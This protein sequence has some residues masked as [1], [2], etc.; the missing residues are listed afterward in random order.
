MDRQ[1]E[2]D[3]SYKGLIRVA[4]PIA[5]GTFVQFLMVFTDNFFLSKVT[6]NALNGAGISAMIYV[7]LSMFIIGLASGE[8]ILVARRNGE[9]RL[10]EAGEVFG[11]ALVVSLFLSVALFILMQ[12]LLHTFLSVFV[13][14]EH[15]LDHT[16]RFLDI[17]SIGIFFYGTSLIFIGFYIGIA[18]SKVLLYTTLITAGVNIFLD[19][20]LIFGNAGFPELGLEGAAWAT[21]TAEICSLVYLVGYAVWH[22]SS[23][24]YSLLQGLTH[25][26][27]GIVRSL[28][29]VSFPIMIQQVLALATWTAFFLIVEKLGEKELMASNIVRN[30]YL[31]IFVALMGVSQTTKTYIST[32]IA[33]ERQA[34]LGLAMKRLLVI[35]IC[36]VLILSHGLWLY[37]GAIASL[38]TQ[39]P[40]TFELTRLSLIFVVPAMFIACF[41]SV[42]LNTIEGS[43][44]TII[45]L[46]IEAVA[47]V[48]YINI[49]WYLCVT[50]PQPIHI[51]WMS[52]YIYF[53]TIALLGYAFLK[54]G[55]WKYN[56][57]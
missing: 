2:I 53:G 4:L 29:K 49:A 31:L 41:S 47:V 57:I 25:L 5:L 38:F 8:Q 39:D 51:V 12:T 15:V 13:Q 9:K 42:L 21:V 36:G 56:K 14:S 44:R 6:M 48:I 20:A 40:E 26:K 45:A 24:S 19:W 23:K 17:R 3:I 22:K 43:G 35:N 11:N 55:T 52:D 10:K 16:F 27:W 7:T 28:S 34:V 33:E 1:A 46:A 30:M 18:S 37:P 54:K 50:N 32:L